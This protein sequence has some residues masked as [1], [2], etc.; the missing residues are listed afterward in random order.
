MMDPSD[1]CLEFPWTARF[2]CFLV[3]LWSWTGGLIWAFITHPCG[4]KHSL[5][6]SVKNAPMYWSEY[7]EFWRA[8][9]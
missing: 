3:F 7:K 8:V 6:I 9:G 1:L 2:I 4:A 5:W